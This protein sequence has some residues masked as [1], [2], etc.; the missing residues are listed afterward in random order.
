[1]LGN[2]AIGF[3]LA[4]YNTSLS[5]LCKFCL[6]RITV[7]KLPLFNPAGANQ[8]SLVLSLN[9]Y[10][11]GINVEAGTHTNFPVSGSLVCNQGQ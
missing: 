5:A 4:L 1:M 7:G 9:A 11:E 8:V 6:A 3:T 10:T 2:V